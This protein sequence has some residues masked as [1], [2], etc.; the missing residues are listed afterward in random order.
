MVRRPLENLWNREA[1]CTVELLPGRFWGVEQRVW[2]VE[3]LLCQ[4]H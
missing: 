1:I 2:H 4:G 3:N